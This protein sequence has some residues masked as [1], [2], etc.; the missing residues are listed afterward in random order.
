VAFRNQW[1]CCENQCR[2]GY[3]TLSTSPCLLITELIVNSSKIT[4]TIGVGRISLLAP[5][6]VHFFGKARSWIP[7]LNK[8]LSGRIKIRGLIKSRDDLNFSPFLYAHPK[9]MPR[10]SAK[11][12]PI[13]ADRKENLLI[14][15]NEIATNNR[16]T[17]VICTTSVTRLFM[18]EENAITKD[19]IKGKANKTKNANTRRCSA[20]ILCDVKNSGYAPNNDSSGRENASVLRLTKPPK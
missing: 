7:A 18:T 13:S 16:K 6:I 1:D 5:L 8:K 17:N 3:K 20:S 15:G 2:F 4:I 12:I 14:I 19:S 10:P 11:P 9:T